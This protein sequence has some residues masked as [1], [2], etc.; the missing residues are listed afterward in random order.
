V[1]YEDWSSGFRELYNETP[2][3]QY[4]ETW[5]AR[6][7]EALFEAG[8]TYHASEYE[9]QGLTEDDVHAIREEFFEYMGLAEENFD[10]DD[11]REAMGYGND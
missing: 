10:W 1:P 3:T 11:W 6:H 7:V 4:V 2:G 5:E 8:F 9:A